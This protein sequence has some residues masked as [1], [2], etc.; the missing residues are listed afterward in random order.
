[1]LLLLWWVRSNHDATVAGPFNQ[2]IELHLRVEF[3]SHFNLTLLTSPSDKGA[4]RGENRKAQ[5][6]RDNLDER[7]RHV[8]PILVSRSR[9][10]HY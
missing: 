9:N 8:S 1:M 2:T 7:R 4:R 10:V 3:T 6:I 5:V